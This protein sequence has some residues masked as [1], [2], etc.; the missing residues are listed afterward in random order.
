MIEVNLPSGVSARL[1][2]MPSEVSK[3]AFVCA[4][5][6]RSQM[7]RLF[8]GSQSAAVCSELGLPFTKSE[9]TNCQTILDHFEGQ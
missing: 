9:S 5:L 2:V 6:D 8:T 1:D 4:F 3:L 7:R